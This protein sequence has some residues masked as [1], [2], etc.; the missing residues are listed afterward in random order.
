MQ[1]SDVSSLFKHCACGTLFQCT[2]IDSVIRSCDVCIQLFQGPQTVTKPTQKGTSLY[3][4][5][6]YWAVH[7]VKLLKTGWLITLP[8]TKISQSF[9]HNTTHTDTHTPKKYKFSNAGVLVKLT[10]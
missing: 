6:L 1:G 7:G 9:N 3:G 4:S 5:Y 2:A 8:K 10:I